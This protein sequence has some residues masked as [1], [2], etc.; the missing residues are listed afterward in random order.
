MGLLNWLLERR[1]AGANGC[2]DAGPAAAL[3]YILAHPV[4]D[5]KQYFVP[6]I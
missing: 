5:C 6:R 2:L 4:A 3:H 1:C